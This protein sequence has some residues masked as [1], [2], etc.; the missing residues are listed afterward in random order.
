MPN[1]YFWFAFSARNDDRSSGSGWMDE[2]CSKQVTIEDRQYLSCD[3][4]HV[5]LFTP[6]GSICGEDD[7]ENG[8]Y[9]LYSSAS[10]VR[11][12]AQ[13][14]DL[15]FETRIP[16]RR[17]SDYGEPDVVVHTSSGGSVQGATFRWI[18]KWRDDYWILN[19]GYDNKIRR[20]RFAFRDIEGGMHYFYAVPWFG[21]ELD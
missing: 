10:L 1:K 7:L 9:S 17:L 6:G 16:W 19:S 3:E 12:G 8:R 4:V 20:T 11:H 14:G 13:E 5:S 21:P 15:D 2:R 18:E